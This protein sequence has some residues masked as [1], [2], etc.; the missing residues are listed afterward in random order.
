VTS[1]DLPAL[2]ATFDT[3]PV[4]ALGGA[5]VEGPTQFG[6]VQDVLVT[7]TGDIW[8]VDHQA[9]EIRV[10]DESG[11][12]L[13]TLGGRG[14][15]PGEFAQV[16]LAGETDDGRVLAVDRVRRRYTWYDLDGDTVD[17]GPIPADDG[18]GVPLVQGV[19]ADGTM[20]GQ[21]TRI[22]T[23]EEAEP[24]LLIDES[25]VV[26][27]WEPLD[28]PPDTLGVAPT[29][30]W[31]I[32]D[33]G[34]MQSIPFT[35]NPG[36]EPGSSLWLT[37]GIYPELQRI[38]PDGRREVWRIEREPRRLDAATRADYLEIADN[39]PEARGATMR[40]MLRSDAVPE[41]VP[42]WRELVAAAD[43][44]LWAMRWEQLFG[45]G[46]TVYDVF[47]PDGVYLGRVEAPE[48][49]RIQSIDADLVTGSW[50]D[51]LGVPHVLRYRFRA[52]RS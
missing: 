19:L 8:V 7:D 42:H 11:T 13:R 25:S 52:G 27:R 48:G 4:L 21:S 31:V 6:N 24:G 35:A 47:A 40:E 38:T 34:R 44:H 32:D 5:E 20:I 36:I 16:A 33:D 41:F 50:Q 14:D 29:A 51:E 17:A 28:G 3:V 15:G 10:F 1:G 2:W 26:V 18:A 39:V 23:M 12:H 46:P 49:L 45:Q 22:L 9:A 37:N 30:S 43:G